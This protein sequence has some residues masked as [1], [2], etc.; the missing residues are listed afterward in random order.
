MFPSDVLMLWL[1]LGVDYWDCLEMLRKAF[2]T[3][4]L[5]FFKKGSLFQLVLAM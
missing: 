3:G 1:R 4:I 5:M 2:I